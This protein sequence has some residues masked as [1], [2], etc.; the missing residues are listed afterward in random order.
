MPRSHHPGVK[1]REAADRRRRVRQIEAKLQVETDPAA[2]R[3]LEAAL[4]Y[5]EFRASV[6]TLPRITE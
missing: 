5:Y 2:R 4:A 1:T 6:P 3:R